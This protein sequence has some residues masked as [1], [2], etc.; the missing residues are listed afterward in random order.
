MS[1]LMN[2]LYAQ[3][4]KPA[5]DAQPQEFGDEARLDLLRNELPPNFTNELNE[6]LRS[7]TIRGFRLGLKTGAA[8]VKDLS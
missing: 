2:W 4:I 3:Y 1:D 6:L 7:C 5:L 8:V